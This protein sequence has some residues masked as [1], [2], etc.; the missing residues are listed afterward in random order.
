M[1]ATR[2]DEPAP[3]IARAQLV[4]ERRWRSRFSLHARRRV[5]A[6]SIKGVDCC[7]PLVALAMVSHAESRQ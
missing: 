2:A 5:A 4:T 7:V 1:I 3:A 6:L